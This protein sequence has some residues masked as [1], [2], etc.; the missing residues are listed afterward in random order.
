MEV[1]KMDETERKRRLEEEEQ[2]GI[3]GMLKV[4]KSSPEYSRMYT[5]GKDFF[6]K[7]TKGFHVPKERLDRLYNTIEGLREV[8]G[9]GM[10]KYFFEKERIGTHNNFASK[11][12]SGTLLFD[13]DLR[14]RIDQLVIEKKA[15]GRLGLEQMEIID[16]I[17]IKERKAAYLKDMIV[18]YL[19]AGEIIPERYGQ[20]REEL[21]KEMDSTFREEGPE[22]PLPETV[23]LRRKVISKIDEVFK[24][25]VERLVPYCEAH[26][27]ALEGRRGDSIQEKIGH[28][29]SG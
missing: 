27:E 18:G 29:L 16:R 20:S 22:M 11:C 2:L 5:L 4:I 3:E 15:E 25:M 24:E 1:N 9:A 19:L 12:I 28:L 10:S 26:P 14:L 8:V 13:E 21:V 17:I 6:E 7:M 23:E